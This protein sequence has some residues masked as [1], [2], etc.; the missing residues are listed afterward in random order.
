MSFKP[1]SDSLGALEKAFSML[2]AEAR[3]SLGH[4][5]ET[6]GPIALTRQA[7]G[8]FIGQGF[9]LSVRL[10]DGSYAGAQADSEESVRARLI[11]AFETVYREKFGRTPPDVP[12][13]LVN[14]RVAGDAP[15]RKRFVPEQLGSGGKPAPKGARQVYFKE[16]NGYV[17]TPIYERSALLAGFAADGPLLVEDASSTLVVGPKGHVEQLPTGNLVITIKD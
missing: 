15:P 4:V 5:S 2:E 8:R 17:S 12:V 13:E 3:S 9:N 7:D 14:L 10:P 11:E 1:A 6:F 16:A